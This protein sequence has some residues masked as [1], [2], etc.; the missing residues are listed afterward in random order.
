MNSENSQSSKQPRGWYKFTIPWVNTMRDEDWDKIC[1]WALEQFGL[2]GIRYLTH[3]ELDSLT[4]LFR[5]ATDLEWMI[6]KWS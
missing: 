4:F 2:P 3:P 6:L 1:I 5:D